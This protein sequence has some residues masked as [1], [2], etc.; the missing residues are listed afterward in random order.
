MNPQTFQVL[1][2][3]NRLDI[4]ELLYKSPRTV[5]EIAGILKM[6]QPQTSK[7]LRV[8]ADAGI[9]VVRPVKNQRYYQLQ[10]QAFKDLDKWLSKFREMWDERFTRLDKLLAK[11]VKKNGR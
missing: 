7:H 5:N 10:P 11:E 9:V 8:L 1:S 3:Q 4:V 6:H 2:E